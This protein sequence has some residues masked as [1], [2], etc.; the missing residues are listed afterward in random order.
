L[1]I[2]A[3]GT[4]TVDG[5]IWAYGGSGGSSGDSSCASNA[6]AGSGGAIRLVANTITGSGNLFAGSGDSSAKHAGVIPL[7]TL[8]TNTLSA[9]STDPVPSRVP[10]TGPLTNPLTA[11]VE[12]TQVGGQTVPTPPQG[13]F[14]GTDVILQTPG[15]VSVRL[16]TSGVPSGTAVNVV[17][18]PRVG[19]AP[20]LQSATLA[21]ANCTTAGDCDVTVTINLPS[22]AHVIEA[23][24]TFQP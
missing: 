24:A 16:A 6:G 10:S 4:L 12:I 18:K 15:L 11:T 1:L 13:V 8:A 21:P 2:V 5:Q 14:R 20:I 23:Q 7:E 22:G 17:A 9:T 3:N 19:V